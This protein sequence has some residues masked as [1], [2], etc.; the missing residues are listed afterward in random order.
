MGR[1]LSSPRTPNQ[2]LEPDPA[3]CGCRLPSGR[4]PR[5]GASRRR[6]GWPVTAGR[7]GAGSA[8]E[9]LRAHRPGRAVLTGRLTTIPQLPSPLEDCSPRSHDPTLETQAHQTVSAARGGARRGDDAI[10]SSTTKS[11][12]LTT[13]SCRARP[14]QPRARR[15]EPIGEGRVVT[16]CTST[17]A[18]VLHGSLPPPRRRDPLHQSHL[19]R[20]DAS[21][22]NARGAP[23]QR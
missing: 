6:S 16:T 12:P 17:A 8:E 23:S 11:P 3:S 7:G 14:V 2:R 5:R 10:T 4:P 19:D 22:L 20:H 13:S 1:G 18:A 9:D 21:A 15:T